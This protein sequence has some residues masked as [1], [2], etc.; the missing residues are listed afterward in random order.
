MSSSAMAVITMTFVPGFVCVIWRQ[1]SSPLN[2]R[3]VQVD[4]DH[5]RLKP[6]GGL[7]DLAA[8]SDAANHV[9]PG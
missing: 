1:T 2:V 6:R 8:I 9:A 4:H 5:D 7:G 3:Q